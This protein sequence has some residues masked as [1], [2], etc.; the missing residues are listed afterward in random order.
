[1][2]I[3]FENFEL[4]ESECMLEKEKEKI[5]EEKIKKRLKKINKSLKRKMKKISRKEAE[6]W[7]DSHNNVRR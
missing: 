1:M 4:P 3:K 7:K 6:A 2:A 5:E